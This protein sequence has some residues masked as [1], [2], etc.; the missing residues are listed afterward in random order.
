M[1]IFI[2]YYFEDQGF[3]KS[4]S[5]S[6]KKDGHRVYPKHLKGF[7]GPDGMYDPDELDEHLRDEDVA[8]VALSK[9]Y[10]RDL[11]LQH[12][13]NSLLT[14]ERKLRPNFVLPVFLEGLEDE[15]VPPKCLS[16]RFVDFREVKA[17]QPGYEMKYEHKVSELR[18]ALSALGAKR[19]SIFIS[20]SSKDLE[21]ATALSD[22]FSAAYNFGADDIMCSSVSGHRLA[23]GVPINESL[24]RKI[25][26]AKSFVGVATENSVG[27]LGAGGS[28]YVAAEWGARWGMK[29][30]LVVM[31]AAGFSGSALRPPFSHE[32]VLSCDDP[33]QV[34]QFVTEL[35]EAMNWRVQPQPF[36]TKEIDKLVAAS[37]AAAA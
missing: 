33:T 22:L 5:K 23:L 29:R 31:L 20:H 24:R 19:L 2:S 7:F 16:K 8:L 1:N 26:E 36:Y 28:F 27:G 37:R 34:Q 11:W 15:D 13:I 14:L 30:S 35:G 10:M 21:I 4:I 12:E 9:K 6:L 18:N 25:R 17:D 3:Y 32:N